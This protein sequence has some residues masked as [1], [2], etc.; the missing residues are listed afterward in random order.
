[1]V[2]FQDEMNFSKLKFVKTRKMRIT[3][4]ALVSDEKVASSRIFVR[5]R[6]II[7]YHIRLRLVDFLAF[8]LLSRVLVYIM[9]NN[10]L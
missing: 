10:I 9:L 4:Y 7:L 8:C 6:P 3:S 5:S 1:M 2:D